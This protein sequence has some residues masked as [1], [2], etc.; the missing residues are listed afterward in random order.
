MVVQ[1][2]FLFSSKILRLINEAKNNALLMGK[3]LIQFIDYHAV[4]VMMVKY[5][6]D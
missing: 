1:A 4:M 5:I 2:L 3:T 6:A